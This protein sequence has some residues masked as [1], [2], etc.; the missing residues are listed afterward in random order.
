MKDHLGQAR[1]KTLPFHCPALRVKAARKKHGMEE[2]LNN[3]VNFFFLGCSH[4]IGM[5]SRP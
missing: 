2:W 5:G 3:L 1:P 4:A